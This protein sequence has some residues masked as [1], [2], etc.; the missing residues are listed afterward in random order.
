M[1][2]DTRDVAATEPDLG[3]GQAAPALPESEAPAGPPS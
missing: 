1:T 3:L 2:I